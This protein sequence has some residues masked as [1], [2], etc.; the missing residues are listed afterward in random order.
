MPSPGASQISSRSMKPIQKNGAAMPTVRKN[1][2]SV[3]GDGA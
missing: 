3:R 2:R 1:T